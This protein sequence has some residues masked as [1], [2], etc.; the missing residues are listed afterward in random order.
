MFES[1]FRTPAVNLFLL[2]FFLFFPLFFLGGGGGWGWG[3]GGGGGGACVCVFYVSEVDIHPLTGAV[4][5]VLQGNDVHNEQWPA[6]SKMAVPSEVQ[7]AYQH[8]AA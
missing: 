4:N 8:L 5:H 3:G 6:D 7:S 2:L 1:Y